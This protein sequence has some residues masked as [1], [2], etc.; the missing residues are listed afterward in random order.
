MVK[1]NI[2]D[3]RMGKGKSSWAIQMM[4][5]NADRNYVYITPFL[6]EVE[7]IKTQCTSSKFYEP[8]QRGKG[9][10]DSLHKLLATGR[11]IASTHALFRTSTEITRELVRNGEY[12]LILD[13]VMDVVEQLQLKVGDIK[14]L[15]SQG[16]ITIG[17]NGII[18]WN[19]E[20]FDY[21][22]RYDDVRDMAKN[23]SLIYVNDKIL[24]W[25]F[26][27]QV[28]SA[29]NEVYIL[30]YKFS[31]QVQRYYYDFHNIEYNYNTIIGEYGNYQLKHLDNLEQLREYDDFES[32]RPLINILDHD[33][34]NN[35]G[36]GKFSLSSGWF[37]RNNNANSSV[38]LDVLQ[39]NI[40]NYFRNISKAKSNDLLWTTL[41]ESR[42]K[43]SG[44]GYS[45]GFLS[46][47]IRATNDY[48]DRHNLA[49][50][51]NVFLN[52]LISTY[53]TDRGVDVNE[54][55]YA[56]SEMLQW[57]W[58]SAIRNGKSINVYIPS[59][60]MRYL[61]MDYLGVEYT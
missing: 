52:P 22:S 40:Y 13:E 28:F 4:N 19:D 38:L 32:L 59:S 6:S 17:E 61:L 2:V 58:R 42:P 15:L 5:D 30:T 60:R 41:K 33:K 1:I 36:D 56:L 27:I 20:N 45:K 55:D 57:I 50:C 18:V 10:R 12:V 39:K 34:L 9:K 51:I 29:F 46:C 49:Y 16:L 47:N 53:F 24:M 48:G 3:A 44:N 54:E 26:P 35:I 31:G 11:N 25:N 37:D 43:L 8:L 23:N 14:I 21:D 7:R